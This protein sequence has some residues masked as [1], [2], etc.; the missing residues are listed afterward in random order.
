MGRKSQGRLDE[1]AELLSLHDIELGERGGDAQKVARIM[2]LAHATGNGL[3]QR[4][5]K[6]L[7][8]QAR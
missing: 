7:G 8:W 1:F 4:I 6:G 2:G 3:L 5:R